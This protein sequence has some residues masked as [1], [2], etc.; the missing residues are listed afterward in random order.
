MISFQTGGRN[1]VRESP[2][3]SERLHVSHC[4]EQH[5]QTAMPWVNLRPRIVAFQKEFHGN[6]N[7]EW[8]W[9]GHKQ[10]NKSKKLILIYASPCMCNSKF[11]QTPSPLKL[12][13]CW[14]T[15]TKH[16]AAPDH[17]LVGTGILTATWKSHS[18]FGIADL[19]GLDRFKHGWDWICTKK[20]QHEPAQQR[21]PDDHHLPAI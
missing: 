12:S 17:E 14:E 7:V 6:P 18:S 19:R 4:R 10:P 13:N 1:K 8:H 20:K 11:R 21:S 9:R 3:F 15:L 16:N 2:D 5:S